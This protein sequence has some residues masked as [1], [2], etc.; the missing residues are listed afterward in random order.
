MERS[1]HDRLLDAGWSYR[2]H[3]ER[4]WIIYKDPATRLWHPRAD[5]IRILEAGEPAALAQ[6]ASYDADKVFA[7][8]PD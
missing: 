4:G 3:P 1:Q 7:K 5:A 8:S 6:P 2:T